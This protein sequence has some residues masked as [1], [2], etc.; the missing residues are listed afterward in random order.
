MLQTEKWKTFPEAMINEVFH[1]TGEI[2]HAL[3]KF[4]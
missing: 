2:A 4:I 1:S 3:Q